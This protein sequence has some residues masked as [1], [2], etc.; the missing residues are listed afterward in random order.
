MNENIIMKMKP[1]D[2]LK[3]HPVL[4]NDKYGYK[5]N[6]RCRATPKNLEADIT[7]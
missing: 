4:F 2:P 5:S 3:P 1:I 6:F 7:M